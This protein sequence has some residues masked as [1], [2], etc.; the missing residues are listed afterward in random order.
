[1]RAGVVVEAVLATHEGH[2]TATFHWTTRPRPVR[3]V[4]SLKEENP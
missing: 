1:V 4:G 3:S 2:A